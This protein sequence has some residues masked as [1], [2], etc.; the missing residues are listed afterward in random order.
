MAE[1][2]EVIAREKG[3]VN[4]PK[5]RGGPT[6]YG[7][8]QR[9][10]S[11][12]LGREATA[13]DVA[14]L[15]RQTAR[16]IIEAEYASPFQFLPKSRLKSLLVDASVQHGPQ[17]AIRWLQRAAGVI[18]D[19]RLGPETISAVQASPEADLYDAV[20][21]FRLGKLARLS[22]TPRGKAFARGWENRMKEFL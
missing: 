14:A 15:D 10:L 12:W 6:K 13:S 16:R 11:N 5:D 7:I 18:P 8:T 3:Y 4:H 19:G 21:Q 1:A 2:D 22:S 20:L 9:T 17:D